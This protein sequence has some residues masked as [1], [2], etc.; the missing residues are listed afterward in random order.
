MSLHKNK[1]KIISTNETVRNIFFRNFEHFQHRNWN[2]IGPVNRIQQKSDWECASEKNTFTSNPKMSDG[3]FF[4]RSHVYFW[5]REEIWPTVDEGLCVCV[6]VCFRSFVDLSRL[7]KNE[8]P[9]RYSFV[10]SWKE[11]NIAVHVNRKK[12][13]NFNPASGTNNSNHCFLPLPIWHLTFFCYPNITINEWKWIASRVSSLGGDLFLRRQSA[14]YAIA[15]EFLF[16]DQWNLLCFRSA[17]EFQ[18]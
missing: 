10:V 15:N 7:T 18:T 16:W 3:V 12:E 8:R 6:Y 9:W 4:S 11:Y 5:F 13:R 17:S 1:P 2:P 14:I